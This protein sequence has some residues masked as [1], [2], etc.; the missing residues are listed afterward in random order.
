MR[1]YNMQM[2]ESKTEYTTLQVDVSTKLKFLGTHIDTTTE[3]KS[4]INNG[5]KA[6][7]KMQNIFKQEKISEKLRIKLY[8]ACIVPHLTYNIG[9]IPLKKTEAESLNKAHTDEDYEWR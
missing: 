1:E 6:L 4:R 7:I 2:N 9:T 8:K 3:V 5:A